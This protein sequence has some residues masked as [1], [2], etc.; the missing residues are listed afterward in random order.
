MH[1]PPYAVLRAQAFNLTEFGPVAFPL[2]QGHCLSTIQSLRHLHLEGV[3]I[4]QSSRFR[5]DPADLLRLVRHQLQTLGMSW[6]Q[7]A[8]AGQHLH[9]G[10]ALVKY[11]EQAP[12]GVLLKLALAPL[13]LEVAADMHTAL[14][15]H[16]VADKDFRVLPFSLQK[17]PEEHVA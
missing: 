16:G 15:R 7:T 5:T 9:V 12:R 6:K 11:V 2:K 10:R 13:P 17:G 8:N 14:E 4:G 3:Y 1:P